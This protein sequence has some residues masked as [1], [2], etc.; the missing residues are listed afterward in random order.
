MNM[1]INP[2]I[3]SHCDSGN[4]EPLQTSHL[5]YPSDTPL[6]HQAPGINSIYICRSKRAWPISSCSESKTSSGDIAAD[7]NKA[8]GATSAGGPHTTQIGPTGQREQVLLHNGSIG[9]AAKCSWT[10]QSMTTARLSWTQRLSVRASQSS[11]YVNRQAE[12]HH[13]GS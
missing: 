6:G 1:K 12:Q 13:I 2:Q 7:S 3:L 9:C 10:T 5:K 11:S 4:T 8:V